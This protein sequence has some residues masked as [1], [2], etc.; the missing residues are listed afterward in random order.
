[1]RRN[2]RRI[3]FRAQSAGACREWVARI[4]ECQ[5]RGLPQVQE[6]GAGQR[7]DDDNNSDDDNDN[8]NS[9]SKSK[10]RSR[11]TP[12]DVSGV[13]KL[14]LDKLR[15]AGEG[16]FNNNDSHYDDDDGHDP[17]TDG[18]ALD[19]E[20]GR[21]PSG[22]DRSRS[23]GYSSQFG[24]GADSHGIVHS[25]VLNTRRPPRSHAVPRA[26]AGTEAGGLAGLDATGPDSV[27][28]GGFSPVSQQRTRDEN[29]P[30]AP[31]PR[32][33]QPSEDGS[34]RGGNRTAPRTQ[35]NPRRPGRGGGGG[36]G[37]RDYF[38]LS[39]SGRRGGRGGRGGQLPSP[40]RPGT[41]GRAGG[42]GGNDTSHDALGKLRSMVGRRGR[43]ASPAGDRTPA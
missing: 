10:S 2:V 13:P 11:R 23:S 28:L 34:V 14:Q 7:T 36:G 35:P 20:Q 6:P 1:M 27:D 3:R 15:E 40:S 8:N 18:V 24:R 43:L 12:G 19:V 32:S 5:V 29:K 37:D 9:S 22:S 42:G 26:R 33:Y 30:L 21:S 17:H 39:A 31:T 16:F 4:L 38:S 41:G 25:V